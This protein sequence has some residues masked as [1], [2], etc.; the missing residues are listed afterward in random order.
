[1][2][3][4]LCDN[5]ANGR[6][7][8]GVYVSVCV[9]VCVSVLW[10][11]GV[12][13]LHHLNTTIAHNPYSTK[14]RHVSPPPPPGGMGG[15]H[16]GGDICQRVEQGGVGGGGGGDGRVVLM[17]VMVLVM[18]MGMVVGTLW[19]WWRVCA[20]VVM[21]HGTPVLCVCVCVRACVCVCVNITTTATPHNGVS[22]CGGPRQPIFHTTNDTS[23]TTTPL[24]FTTFDSI[25]TTHVTHSHCLTHTR[26]SW[27]SFSPRYG[28]TALHSPT[29][30]G[31]FSPT[32]RCAVFSVF[33]VY[34]HHHQSP[35]PN[36]TRSPPRP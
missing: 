15:V 33:A 5:L 19:W 32:L 22:A 7:L 18:V 24:S 36:H 26:R 27:K 17:V 16:Y 12:K 13:Y 1:M 9:C 25:H 3:T 10:V 34:H 6:G 8:T 28:N 11:T 30:C 4:L 20:C 21:A 31:R 35:H 23:L 14:S 2:C 29:N